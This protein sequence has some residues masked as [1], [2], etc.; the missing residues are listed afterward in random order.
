MEIGMLDVIGTILATTAIAAALT[1][2]ASTLPIQLRGRLAL[3]VLAGV[4]VGLAAAVA[5][6]GGFTNPATVLI[7]FAIPMP[8]LIG[9]NL[10]RVGGVL[11]VLLAAAGRLAGP[12]PHVA[13]WG[14]FVTGALAMPVA[15]LAMAKSSQRDRLIVAWNAFGALDLVVAVTLGIMSRNG[16]PLQL[17][18]AGVG[19]EAMTTLPWSLV[20]SVLVPFFLI[21]HAIVFAQL[22]ARILAKTTATPISTSG[23]IKAPLTIR[24][25]LPVA[26]RSWR[27][28][29]TSMPIISNTGRIRPPT[30]RPSCG[31]S[32]G[33]RSRR[34]MAMQ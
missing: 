16:S 1:A 23:F 3:A 21:A 13:G 20:P 6:A 24:K 30:S 27:S 18:H 12:F 25:A 15:R 33:L 17:I 9:L 29:C 4:W 7:M 10:I 28:T 5:G 22:R 11:F 2:V 14:D 19:T 26:S 34:D 32:I 8:L 31:T